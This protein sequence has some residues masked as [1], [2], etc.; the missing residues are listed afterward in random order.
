MSALH[1]FEIP[2]TDIERATKFYGTILDTE[3]P[4]VDMTEQMGS[5]LGMLPD[6]GGVGGAL[7][8]NTQYGYV[9]SQAGT[10]VY[11]QLGD[12]DLN[13]AVEKVAAT[14]GQVLLPK[15]ALGENGYCA[16]ILD[17]E[18]NRVG[19]YATQ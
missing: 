14:G 18:G 6:R 9:P 13:L 7:V 3:I 2:V 1:W 4:I 17:P 8:Q 15:T 12:T 5:M 10:L 16:W 11:L 19:L